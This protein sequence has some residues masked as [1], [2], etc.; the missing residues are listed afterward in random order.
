MIQVVLNI[1]A[2]KK[3]YG[4]DMLNMSNLLIFLKRSC[5]GFNIMIHVVLNLLIFFEK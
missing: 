4:C 2:F 1:L 5:H 3:N